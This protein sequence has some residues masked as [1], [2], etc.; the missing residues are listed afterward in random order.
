MVVHKKEEA[1]L[2]WGHD[3]MEKAIFMN[4]CVPVMQE[5]G[6]D[7]IKTFAYFHLH[8]PTKPLM[9]RGISFPMVMDIRTHIMIVSRISPDKFIGR[10]PPTQD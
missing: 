3:Y 2:T 7:P 6:F 1:Q 9:T 5:F 8:V 10:M 4:S